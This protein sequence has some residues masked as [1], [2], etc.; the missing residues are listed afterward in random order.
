MSTVLLD[1]T[2]VSLLHPKKKNN[3]IR[4]SYEPHMKEEV[5]AISFQSVAEL[6]KWAEKQNWGDK[7]KAGLD[8]FI[9]RFLVYPYDYDLAKIWA[10]VS[11]HSE[12]IGRRLEAGDAW[13][14]ATAV[15]RKIP[16]L[17]HDKDMIDLKIPDLNVISYLDKG[18]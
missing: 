9:K 7:T 17:T 18:A 1:T 14:V 2:V 15:H 3:A 11:S 4:A 12:S 13:V 8:D 16:L 5:L 6:W 10:Q